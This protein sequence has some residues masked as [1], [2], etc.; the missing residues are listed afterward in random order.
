MASSQGPFQ[1]TVGVSQAIDPGTGAVSV[2][3]IN[4]SNYA[5]QVQTG[6]GV[7]WLPAWTGDLFR[8]PAPASSA[9]QLMPQA[10]STAQNP[11]SAAVL[12]CSYFPGD[13]ITGT[14]PYPL[15]RQTNLGNGSLPTAVTSVVND[16][17]PAATQVLEATPVGQLTSA[18]SFDNSGNVVIRTLDNSVWKTVFQIAAGGAGS[19]TQAFSTT[20]SFNKALAGADAELIQLQPT[21]ASPV[22]R[23]TIN[24]TTGNS[25]LKIINNTNGSRALIMYNNGQV[26]LIA[27]GNNGLQ[28]VTT[29][30]GAATGTYTHGLTLAPNAVSVLQNVAAATN[31]YGSDTYGSTTVHINVNASPQAF[32]AIA[33]R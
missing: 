9:V 28:G 12:I 19:T 17:S 26:G 18:F 4:E 27:M 6:G 11:P 30:T 22:A 20:L 29:F 24:Y 33:V 13:L 14:Y 21:D 23:W 8:L 2:E 10:L 7:E 32:T 3:I 15:N 25:A 1:L 5:I 31:T 16:G